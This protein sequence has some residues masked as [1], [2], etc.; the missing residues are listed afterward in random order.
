MTINYFILQITMAKYAIA[1]CELHN[2]N[3]HGKTMDSSNDIENHYLASYILTPEEFY[4][5]EWHDIIENMKNMYENSENNLTHSNI[6][7][8]K[9]IIENKEY[10]TPNIVDLTYLPGNECVASLKTNW[11]K[12][13]QKEWRRV[14]N[15]RKEIE[16]G[17]KTISAQKE[18][19]LTGNWPKHLRNWPMMKL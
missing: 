19:Q 4:G 13:V 1:I 18:R 7:N 5:N 10:F 14:Y 8:Y 11:L 17:R 2:T 9:H 15:C 3:L 16:N 12:R 6:R